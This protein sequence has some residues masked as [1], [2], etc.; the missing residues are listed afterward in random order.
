MQAFKTFSRGSYTIKVI[1]NACRSTRPLGVRD[2][3]Y[4]VRLKNTL[5]QK[6]ALKLGEIGLCRNNDWA[7]TAPGHPPNT[8]AR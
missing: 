4:N 2:H 3:V 5:S 1:S 6:Q 8:E 7:K